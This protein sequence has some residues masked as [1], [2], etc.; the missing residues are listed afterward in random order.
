MNVSQ[1]ESIVTVMLLVQGQQGFIFGFIG[2]SHP[3]FFHPHFK[4]YIY[5]NSRIVPSNVPQPRS[6]TA[7][8]A[9]LIH[10]AE[11]SLLHICV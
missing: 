6:C 11:K 3:D 5:G 4:F 7:F 9:C 2:V 8:S 10:A 1:S